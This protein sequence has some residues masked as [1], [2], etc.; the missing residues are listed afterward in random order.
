M[1]PTRGSIRTLFRPAPLVAVA[2]VLCGCGLVAEQAWIAA[3][4]ELA[5]LLIDRAFERT[6]DDGA[7]HRPWRWADT[8][9]VARLE[10]PRLSVRRTV[11]AGA[12]GTSL[13]FGPGHVDGTAAPNSDGNCV[14]AG[15]RDTWFAFLE[16]LRPGDTV[17]VRT[18]DGEQGYRV[19]DRSVRSMWD[20]RVVEP[21][22]RA[23]LT[24]VTCYPFR[25]LTSSDR[26]Y[27]VTL[28]KKGTDLFSGGVKRLEST[29]WPIGK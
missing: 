28:R 8:H 18:V 3:K 22:T 10:V 2:A 20:P 16:H 14:I 24:L 1:N 26:R 9:P 7:P 5:E 23:Q 25:A 17:N 13:A 11:L 27:V 21:T 19:A 6:L 15:H 29:P 12:S 4:A